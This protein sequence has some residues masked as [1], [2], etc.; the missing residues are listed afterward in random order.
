MGTGSCDE[1]GELAMTG[2]VSIQRSVMFVVGQFGN[3]RNGV[4]ACLCDFRLL[5]FRYK[6]EGRF[7]APLNRPHM[8][9]DAS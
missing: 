8:S 5:C 6:I 1:I 4:A 3:R 9:L 7:M 2:L